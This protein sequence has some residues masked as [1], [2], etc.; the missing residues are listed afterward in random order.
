VGV[1]ATVVALAA[2]ALL[3]PPPASADPAPSL[4]PRTVEAVQQKLAELGYLPVSGVD[5]TWDS[6]SQAATI[7]FQKWEGLDRDGIPGPLTQGA[8]AS[9]QR[10]KPLTRGGG[11]RMEVLLDRQL[12][13]LVRDGRVARAIHVST[14]KR[15]F[16]TPTGRYEIVRKRRKSW[17]FPYKV[18][19]P[20]A[21]YFVRGIA[22]HQSGLVPVRPASHGCVRVPRSSARWLFRRAI[23]GTP[24]TVL[25]RSRR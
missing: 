9:A 3:V 2:L 16:R 20:W 22:I 13:L 6:Q 24:V 5:G 19:L 15:G 25:A 14:G 8:L 1:G 23:V 12:L 7:A 17:S 21:S 18:W 11:T 4:R 10:P